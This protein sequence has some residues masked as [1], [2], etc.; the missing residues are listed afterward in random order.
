MPRKFLLLVTL[1]GDFG[2]FTF[3]E[4]PG[5]PDDILLFIGQ[6]EIHGFL[7]NP[8][9]ASP[10]ISKIKDLVHPVAGSPNHISEILVSLMLEEG[11]HGPKE[12]AVKPKGR[13]SWAQKPVVNDFLLT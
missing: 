10:H 2:K 8:A 6:F 9:I 13:I 3:R 11:H 4:C 12:G 7:L 1:L 5:R